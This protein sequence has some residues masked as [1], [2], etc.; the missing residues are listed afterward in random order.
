MQN[1]VFAVELGKWEQD[2]NQMNVDSGLH[3]ELDHCNP[4]RIILSIFLAFACQW[5]LATLLAVGNSLKT[6]HLRCIAFLIS[7]SVAHHSIDNHGQSRRLEN[8]LLSI[9]N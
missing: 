1:P 5:D 2:W 4:I 3:F 7:C 8:R 9:I 6:R